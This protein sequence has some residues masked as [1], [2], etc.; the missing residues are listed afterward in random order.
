MLNRDP[1]DK[2]LAQE[3]QISPQRVKQYRQTS[4]APM[5]LD[6]P[7]DDDES[8]R[9]SEMVTDPN[10]AAPFDRIIQK[11]DTEL[12]QEALTTLPKRESEVLTLRF[13]LKN[14]TPRT[15]E[16]VGEHFGVTR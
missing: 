5:S 13:G 8:N 14:G 15:L 16:E 4:Q 12:V 6:A 11:T 10:A 1:T 9:I 2:E 7:I 3:L